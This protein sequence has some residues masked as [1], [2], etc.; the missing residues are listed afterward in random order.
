MKKEAEKKQK[1]TELSEQ[2]KAMNKKLS[3]WTFIVPKWRH[4]NFITDPA[5]FFE[6]EKP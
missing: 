5:D 4:D 2:I 3:A 6:K 1:Q